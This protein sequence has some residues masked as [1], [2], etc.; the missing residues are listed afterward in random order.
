MVNTNDPLL[1]QINTRVR[2]N[3]LSHQLGRAAALDG[4]LLGEGLPKVSG[5]FWLNR[6]T[7]KEAGP[8]H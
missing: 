6:A 4:G 7:P 2:L 1:Y 8:L 3:E 5:L